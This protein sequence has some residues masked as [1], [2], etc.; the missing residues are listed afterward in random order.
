M[1]TQKD[2][3]NQRQTTLSSP[4]L[5]LLTLPLALPY[6]KTA[7]CITCPVCSGCPVPRAL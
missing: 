3:P 4:P 7:T 2:K 5:G 1:R 6:Y